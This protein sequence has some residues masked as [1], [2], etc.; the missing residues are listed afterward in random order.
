MTA[1]LFWAFF[2]PQGM[3][4]K[5][6]TADEWNDSVQVATTARVDRGIIITT[7]AM[8]AERPEEGQ[9]HPG[10]AWR[11]GPHGRH[12]L[13]SSPNRN[14]EGLEFIPSFFCLVVVRAAAIVR[15]RK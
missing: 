4:Q 12:G 11:H 15:T 7:E 10:Y 8:V 13:L 9:W 6:H 2:Q 14:D 3:H 5:N 1:H